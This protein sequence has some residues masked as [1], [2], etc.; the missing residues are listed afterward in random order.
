MSVYVSWNGA[1]GVQSWKVYAAASASCAAERKLV[2]QVARSGFET[3]VGNLAAAGYV[4]VEAVGQSRG[5]GTEGT[6]SLLVAVDGS[7]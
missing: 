4:Q 5:G 7:C 3:R 2:A 6:R 1:T